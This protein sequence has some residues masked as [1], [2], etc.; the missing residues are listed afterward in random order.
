MPSHPFASAEVIPVST[1]PSADI[2]SSISNPP[3]PDHTTQHDAVHSFF[4]HQKNPRKWR[5][6]TRS[7]SIPVDH[8][9]KLPTPEHTPSPSLPFPVVAASTKIQK[10][11]T[12]DSFHDSDDQSPIR[13]RQTRR[14]HGHPTPPSSPRRPTLDRFLPAR[15][16]P[17]SMSKSFRLSKPV[18]QLTRDELLLRT[19]SASPDP[20]APRSPRRF[21]DPSRVSMSGNLPMSPNGRARP[22][23][24]FQPGADNGLAVRRVTPGTVWNIGGNAPAE[25]TRPVNAIPNGRGG[26]LG[27]GTNAPMFSSHFFESETPDESSERFE[28]RLA[29]ALEIDQASRTLHI[30]PS[31]NRGPRP[32]PHRGSTAPARLSA[33]T[34]TRWEHGG[35]VNDRV[36]SRKCSRLPVLFEPCSTSYIISIIASSNHLLKPS[37]NFTSLS[38]NIISLSL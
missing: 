16:S 22:T 7:T 15:R 20:F 5:I 23:A 32:S 2:S 29:A 28:G 13:G 26:L 19:D 4:V 10:R 25:P 37:L 36:Q 30:S 27:S 18:Q 3:S 38:L 33:T 1:T 24:T 6:P 34:R 12:Y 14:R 31:P 21:I 11:G 8:P 17:D 35:W 9:M